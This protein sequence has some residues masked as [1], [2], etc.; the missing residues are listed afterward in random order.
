MRQHYVIEMQERQSAS[1][2]RTVQILK[3]RLTRL[4]YTNLMPSSE[5]RFSPEL[6]FVLDS[7]IVYCVMRRTVLGPL[8]HIC[9]TAKEASAACLPARSA[10]P[11]TFRGQIPQKA[12]AEVT[13]FE[14]SL[15]DIR[16]AGTECWLEFCLVCFGFLIGTILPPLAGANVRYRVL[17]PADEV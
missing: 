11:R 8:F 15:T 16:K 2:F 5:L 7:T 13:G 4:K 12:H 17:V 9:K 1:L 10:G 6:Q 14:W 3:A